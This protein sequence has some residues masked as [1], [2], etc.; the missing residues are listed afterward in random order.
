MTNILPASAIYGYALGAGFPP[1]DAVI[2]TAIT[3]PESSANADA[4]QQNVPY[5][6]QGWGL[7]QIT[8]G[9]SVPSVGI[10]YQLLNPATNA[11]AAFLKYVGDGWRFGPWTT[12]WDGAYLRWMG[13]AQA[14]ADEWNS[15]GGGGGTSEKGPIYGSG[16]PAFDTANQQWGSTQWEYAPRMDDLYRTAIQSINTAYTLR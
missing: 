15:G 13:W 2:A 6:L 14:G 11:R 5:H 3:M 10:D 4:I 9:N 12:F 1:S 16:N 8:P 7:W